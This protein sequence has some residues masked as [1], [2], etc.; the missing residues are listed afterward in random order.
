VTTLATVVTV[1]M[2]RMMASETAVG[3]CGM[4]G[5]S[6][7]RKARMSLTPMKPRITDRPVDR[8]TSRSSSPRSRK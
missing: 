4:D 2:P 3:T 6:S 5:S 1:R 7:C 8:N